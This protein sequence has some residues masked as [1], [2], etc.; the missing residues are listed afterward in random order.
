MASHKESEYVQWLLQ[1][2]GE[3]SAVRSTLAKGDNPSRE[4]LA[5][6]ILLP[7]AG[8][9]NIDA[10]RLHAALIAQHPSIR[11]SSEYSDRLGGALRKVSGS[12]VASDSIEQRILLLQG[13]PL[14]RAHKVIRSLLSA[15]SSAGRTVDLNVESL[16]WTYLTW[17]KKSPQFPARREILRDF[18]TASNAVPDVEQETTQESGQ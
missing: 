4:G 6:S 16:L 9:W 2:I 7:R 12:I 10:R 1:R 18:Y 8:G 11:D 14:V 13:M 5:E 3:N 15:A 17:D